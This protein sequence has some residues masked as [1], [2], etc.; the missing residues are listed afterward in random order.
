M[1]AAIL[2]DHPIVADGLYKILMN[3]FAIN[4]I[5]HFT[6]GDEFSAFLR[7]GYQGFDL[8]LL[9]I[10]MPGK[11]GIEVCKDIKIHHPQT[12]I[13]VFSNHTERS[14]IMQMLNNGANGYILKN[15]SSSEIVFGIQEALN[16][17]I[18]FSKEVKEIIARPSA[19]DLKK[20]PTLTKREKQILKMIS[21][22]KTSVEIGA[23]LFLSPFTVDTHRRNLMQ[24]FEVK[25][26]VTLI[27][28][29]SELGVS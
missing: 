25:N 11:S 4:E 18:S 23:E 17:Q 16:G 10:T 26:V 8:I 12:C 29:T 2:D 14:L 7:G 20:I 1:N 19:T 6:S 22:G 15:A 28:I 21:D 27:K 24:K 5:V 9:D 3:S 13:V